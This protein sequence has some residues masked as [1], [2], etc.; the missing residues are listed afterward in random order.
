[1]AKRI[2][3]TGTD[4]NVG[5]TYAATVLGALLQK[6]GYDVGYMK[7][8]Q[9]AGQDSAFVKKQLNI[10]D[11]D[12]LIN[13]FFAPEALSPHLALKRAKNKFNVHKVKKALKKL[14][15]R[16]DVILIEGAGGIMVPLSDEYFTVDLIRDLDASLVIVSRPGLGTINHTLLTINQAKAYGLRIK[17]IVFSE[18]HTKKKTL[19]EQ[20]NPSEIERLSGIR[21]LGCIPHL[22]PINTT[23]ILKKCAKIKLP[24]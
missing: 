19:P 10:K 6:Q 11:E 13:P 8:V 12:K 22:N 18:T 14:E 24:V 4:T 20:T 2:F 5:K 17:G 9:C 1:M 15:K 23:Q 7:P 3:I 21:V 16:H